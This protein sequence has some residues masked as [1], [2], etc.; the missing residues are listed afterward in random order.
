MRLGGGDFT[1]SG[2]RPFTTKI[3]CTSLHERAQPV[4]QPE[5]SAANA[6]RLRDEHLV[7]Q[8]VLHGLVRRKIKIPGPVRKSKL[9][10]A[11]ALHR[12][13]D[14]HAVDATPA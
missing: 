10:G 12:H 11:F 4:P 5:P 13:V 7:D 8:A 9:R 14:L 6:L 2:G 3:I 1:D